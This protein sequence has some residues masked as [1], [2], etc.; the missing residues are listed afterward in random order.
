MFHSARGRDAAFVA[1]GAGQPRPGVQDF[2][3]LSR[4]TGKTGS[5]DAKNT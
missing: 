1:R 4:P 3:R 5:I 2:A